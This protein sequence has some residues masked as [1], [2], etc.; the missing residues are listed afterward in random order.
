MMKIGPIEKSS[1]FVI[2]FL[3]EY[4]S[5]GFGAKNKR[6]IDILVMNLLMN[7]VDLG[8]KSNQELSILLRAPISKIKGLR[9]EAR[10]KYPPDSDY[11]KREFLY[12]LS[13]SQFDLEKGKVT[14]VMEDEFIRHAI[15][16]QLKSKGLFSDTSFN[17]ELVRIDKKSL[18]AVIEELYGNEIAEDFKNGFD[19][20]TKQLEGN[21]SSLTDEFTSLITSFAKETAKKL[22]F[23]FISGRIGF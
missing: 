16:G 22:A 17:T 18:E 6:D 8:N 5:A 20:M 3:E 23:D 10:L 9:Y 15:Q 13:K 19:E 2:E 4:L 7:Y 14:F 12:I 1:E 11:V 21:V